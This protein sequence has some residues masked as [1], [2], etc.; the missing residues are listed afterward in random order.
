[1]KYILYRHAILV[2]LKMKYFS[3]PDAAYYCTFPSQTID[4]S[5]APKSPE[6]EA[7]DK[8]KEKSKG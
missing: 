4:Y 3:R 6:K 8:D 1:M 7:K 5:V 2:T